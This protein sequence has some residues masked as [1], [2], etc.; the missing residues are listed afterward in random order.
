MVETWCFQWL[1]FKEWR[2]F[3]NVESGWKWSFLRFCYAASD[4]A[5]RADHFQCQ[6][7]CGLTLAF[8]FLEHSQNDQ[9]LRGGV[10]ALR[11]IILNSYKFTTANE[12]LQG[13]LRNAIVQ[14]FVQILQVLHSKFV[15][16]SMSSLQIQVVLEW[17]A[18]FADFAPVGKF[19][20]KCVKPLQKYC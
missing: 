4:R 3:K 17:A 7:P 10:K 19:C 14:K 8:H 18:H 9:S 15:K 6:N 11:L 1:I 5:H 12:M 13:D 2:I 16:S 20:N